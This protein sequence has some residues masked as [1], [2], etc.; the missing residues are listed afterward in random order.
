MVMKVDVHSICQIPKFN[1]SCWGCC[2]RGFRSQKDV[3]RQIEKNTFEFKKIKVPSSI[4]LLMF[5]DRFSD[6]NWDVSSSGVC[7]NLVKF[8]NG[9]YAC[10]LHKYINDLVSKKEFLAIHKK[11]LRWEHCDVNFECESVILFDNLSDDIKEEYI[12]WLSNHKFNHYEYSIGNIE[13][14]SIRKFLDERE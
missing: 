5:R 8:K 7:S 9:V 12:E 6:D 11:D 14:T 1:L 4:R 2:G 3:E 10:P 13:G